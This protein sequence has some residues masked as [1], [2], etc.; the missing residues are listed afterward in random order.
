MSAITFGGSG[1]D[2]AQ[3]GR[4]ARRVTL[5]RAVT[6]STLTMNT[7]ENQTG[8]TGTLRLVVSWMASSTSFTPMKARM[9]ASPRLR[10]CSRSEQPLQ[11]EVE[12]AQAHERERVGGEHEVRLA[13]DP[14][15]RRDAVEGEEQVGGADGQHDDG[16]RGERAPPGDARRQ[17]VPSYSGTS[18]PGPIQRMNPLPFGSGSS[19]SAVQTFHAVK[20]R[21]APNR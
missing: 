17:L 2:P 15:H 21:N 16:H 19:S 3:P 4:V 20:S 7:S 6:V 14:E 18:G 11:Q 13:G 1:S 10:C 9:I 8:I 12:L 5:V